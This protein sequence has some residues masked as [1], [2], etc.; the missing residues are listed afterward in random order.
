MFMSDFKTLKFKLQTLKEYSTLQPLNGDLLYFELKDVKSAVEW[1][2][3]KIRLMPNRDEK[4]QRHN[5][6]KL[7][8]MDG[9]G[10]GCF[11]VLHMIDE[12]FEDVK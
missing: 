9:G 10:V 3:E 5:K 8:V 7:C 2:K 4:I 6:V 11:D 12:A 1:L